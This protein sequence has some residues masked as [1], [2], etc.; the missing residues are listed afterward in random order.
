MRQTVTAQLAT[1]TSHRTF[2]ADHCNHKNITF[3][4][5]P[6]E[7]SLVSIYLALCKTKLFIQDGNSCLYCIQFMH[8]GINN[9]YFKAPHVQVFQLSCCQL[10]LDGFSSESLAILVDFKSKSG[11]QLNVLSLSTSHHSL[12]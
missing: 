11:N 10:T 6:Q 9:F 5:F 1:V 7:M 12:V 2:S 4:V 8:I 3:W